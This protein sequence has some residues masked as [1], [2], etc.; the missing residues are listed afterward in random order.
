MV[1]VVF[2]TTRKNIMIK[3]LMTIPHSLCRLVQP[4]PQ[5]IGLH[6]S[7]LCFLVMPLMGSVL[8]KKLI[9]VEVV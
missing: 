4:S 3:I 9:T 7:A 2:V 5:V 8:T 1:M 6:P